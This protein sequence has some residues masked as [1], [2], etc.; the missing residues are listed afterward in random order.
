M[1]DTQ[2]SVLKLELRN[3]NLCY[4]SIHLHKEKA[5][6]L[7]FYLNLYGIIYIKIH[8]YNIIQDEIYNII[9][10]SQR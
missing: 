6:H 9:K 5:Y 4:I 8:I 2:K 10:L 3:N 7:Q 1:L